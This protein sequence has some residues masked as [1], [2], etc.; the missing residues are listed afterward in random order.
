M[1]SIIYK[2]LIRSGIAIA[3]IWFFSGYL[4]FQFRWIA[5]AAFF[6]L[7]VIYPFVV[8]IKKFQSENKEVILD[9][10]CASCRHFDES[11]VLCMK[12]DEH[13]RKDYIPCGGIH[14]EPL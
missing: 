2:A 4:N 5:A 1:G 8:E 7:I 10:I 14:W 11:A 13:V 6:F 3:A 9:T 12:H